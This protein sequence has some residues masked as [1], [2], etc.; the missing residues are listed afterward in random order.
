MLGEDLKATLSIEDQ[1]R[2]ERHIA[3]CSSCARK[4][5]RLREVLQAANES[6]PSAGL[7]RAPTAGR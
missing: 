2:L 4:V 5:A 7:T 1:L 6:R 3:K